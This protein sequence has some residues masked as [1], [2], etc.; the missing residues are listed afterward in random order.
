[1]SPDETEQTKRF[2]FIEDWRQAW[3]FWSVRLA[4]AGGALQALLAWWPDAA[5]ALWNSMPDEV[6]GLLPQGAVMTLPL[7]FFVAS[8]VARV[9]KQGGIGEKG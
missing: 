9:V 2:E 1:M 3:R 4:A 8:I 5:L 7:L 6:K